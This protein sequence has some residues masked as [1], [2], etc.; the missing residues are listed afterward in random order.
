MPPQPTCGVH[1]LAADDADMV[2][3]LQVLLSSIREAV[4]HVGCRKEMANEREAI[5]RGNGWREREGKGQGSQTAQR[6]PAK[7]SEAH[8]P[9]RRL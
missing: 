6:C 2:C 4:V 5:K 3:P 1:L 7:P 9:V 8:P